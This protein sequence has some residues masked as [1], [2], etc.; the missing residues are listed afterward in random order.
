MR[1][2]ADEGL[3]RADTLE[4]GTGLLKVYAFGRGDFDIGEVGGGLDYSHRLTT[5]LSAFANGEI[6]YG[7]GRSNPLG[8]KALA[9]LRWQF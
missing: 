2:L 4:V 9:G 1:D 6:G 5:G 8:W 3:D 7:W